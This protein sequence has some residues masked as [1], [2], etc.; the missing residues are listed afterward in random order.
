MC[1][2][3]TP[4]TPVPTAS[5]SLTQAEHPLP[6]PRAGRGGVE[7]WVDP[8]WRAA[9]AA[10]TGDPQ[11][12]LELLTT[13]QPEVWLRRIPRRATFAWRPEPGPASG[14][15]A[16]PVVVKRFVGDLAR[17]RWYGR[18]R[19]AEHVGPARREGRNLRALRAQGF[20]VPRALAWFEEPGARGRSA[21]VMEHL[22]HREHLRA[23]LEREAG[24]GLEAGRP[25]SVERARLDRLAALVARL[26]RAGWYHRDLYLEHVVVTGPHPGELALLDLGR[27][28]CEPAPRGRWFVKDVAALLSSAPP[29]VGARA[30]LRFL[31]RY[32]DGRGVLAAADR[33]RFQQAVERKAAVLASHA[34]RF[35][36]I[37][38]D[39]L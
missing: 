16:A 14:S 30:R 35:V 34:P 11:A 28:R 31:A 12:A 26:H 37:P 29:C 4:A 20:P 36:D 32:L 17:D 25:G 10:L 21:L 38:P 3:T 13:L 23:L 33:R 7:G 8:A 22:D 1:V 19:G 9:P 18:L 5:S 6:C 27:A 39:P 24:Q 15:V 2:D